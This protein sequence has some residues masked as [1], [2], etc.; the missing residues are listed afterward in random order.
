MHGFYWSF[1]V[2]MFPTLILHVVQ[3][4]PTNIGCPE[5]VDTK[6]AEAHVVK[7]NNVRRMA[8]VQILGE[9]DK[10]I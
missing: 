2:N 10:V 4:T 9:D 5:N 6:Q 1:E 8:A 7:C 3:C